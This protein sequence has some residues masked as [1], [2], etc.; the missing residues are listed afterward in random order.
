MTLTVTEQTLLF[1]VFTVITWF[2][3]KWGIISIS[4]V[5]MIGLWWI[6]R[7]YSAILLI[8]IGV[9]GGD[10][11]N[12]WLKHFIGR[13]RP[14]PTEEGFSFPSGHAMVGLILYGFLCYLIYHEKQTYNWLS[15]IMILTIILVGISRVILGVHYVSDVIGG[16]AIGGVILIGLISIYD[17]LLMRTPSIIRKEK[18]VSG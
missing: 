10:F 6:K 18:S 8:I 11:V 5:A 17:I 4:L 2:G 16:F 3:S 7:N 1:E 12:K 9:L 13:E 15:Y 14:L